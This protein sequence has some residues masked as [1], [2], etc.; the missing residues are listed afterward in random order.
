MRRFVLGFVLLAPLLLWLSATVALVAT[1]PIWL[2]FPTCCVIDDAAMLGWLY[3]LPKLYVVAA[4]PAAF[5][6]SLLF[7]LYAWHDEFEPIA[8][9]ISLL[10][11]LIGF[12]LCIVALDVKFKFYESIFDATSLVFSCAIFGV[13]FVSTALSALMARRLSRKSIS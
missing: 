3:M 6:A 13:L 4:F 10:V 9:F 7:K 11:A 1:A 2:S 5:V 8:M 12:F